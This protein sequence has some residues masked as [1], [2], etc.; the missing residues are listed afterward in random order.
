MLKW[1]WFHRCLDCLLQYII[2]CYLNSFVMCIVHICCMLHIYYIILWELKPG[3]AW[4]LKSA[5]AWGCQWQFSMKCLFKDLRSALIPSLPLLC[6]CD[7]KKPVLEISR[8]IQICSTNRRAFSHSA[9]LLLVVGVDSWQ[10]S[11]LWDKASY[12][13]LR[14]RVPNTMFFCENRLCS[15]SVHYVQLKMWG[16][17]I[18]KSFSS[19][20]L[21]LKL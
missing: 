16:I 20:Y 14:H 18:Q 17:L 12:S 1:S 6:T 9:P 11:W 4:G 19:T 7:I 5:Q 8:Q 13:Q 2:F 21:T 3:T 10:R 15:I